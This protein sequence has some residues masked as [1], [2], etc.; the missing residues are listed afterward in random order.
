MQNQKKACFLHRFWCR[1][2]FLAEHFCWS[3]VPPFTPAL[4]EKISAWS[5]QLCRRSLKEHK[6]RSQ[7]EKIRRAPFTGV[8]PF[9][10]TCPA[11]LNTEGLL[12]LDFPFFCS[13]S[14]KI[15]VGEK[16]HHQNTFFPESLRLKGN[17][18]LFLLFRNQRESC[19]TIWSWQEDLACFNLFLKAPRDALPSFASAKASAA[20][21]S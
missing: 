9:L 19:L 11:P 6:W 1:R 8:E 18:F 14:E 10:L 4:L 21:N 16:N 5:P 13:G 12:L 17:Y 15:S 3:P 20:M 7:C 2:F